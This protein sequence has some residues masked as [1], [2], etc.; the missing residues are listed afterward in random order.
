MVNYLQLQRQKSKFFE[1]HFTLKAPSG[2]A[3]QFE[4]NKKMLILSIEA[5]SVA[6]QNFTFFGF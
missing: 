1:I 2:L 5:N 6:F 3:A 4:K